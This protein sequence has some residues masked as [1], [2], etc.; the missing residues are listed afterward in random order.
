[1][2]IKNI[3]VLDVDKT[4]LTA[5]SLVVAIEYGISFEALKTAE[6]KAKNE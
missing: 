6:E 3:R 4:K 2:P 1:M 5:L